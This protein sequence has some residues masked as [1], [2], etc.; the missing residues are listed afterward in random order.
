MLDES[1]H[2][3][4]CTLGVYETFWSDE[5]VHTPVATVHLRVAHSDENWTEKKTGAQQAIVLIAY[6][7]VVRLLFSAIIQ[8][9][10]N[11]HLL[12]IS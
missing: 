10:L 7:V 9:I 4:I 1:I 3:H 6:A 5:N 12:A 2:V 11:D 8:T